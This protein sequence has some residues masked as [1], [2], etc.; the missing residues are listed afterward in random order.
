MVKSPQIS[1]QMEWDQFLVISGKTDFNTKNSSI[2][3]INKNFRER[4]EV[5]NNMY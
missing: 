5:V 2:C 1:I 3:L 4:K